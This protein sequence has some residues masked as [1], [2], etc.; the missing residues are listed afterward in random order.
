M[1]CELPQ[2]QT[3]EGAALWGQLLSATL[4]ALEQRNLER[5]NGAADVPDTLEDLAEENQV[6]PFLPLY[7]SMCCKWRR[8]HGRAA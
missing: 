5:Q 1:L 6:L 3:A 8:M 2:L 4:K 7:S